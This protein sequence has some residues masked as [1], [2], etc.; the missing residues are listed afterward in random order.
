MKKVLA[1]VLVLVMV[2]GMSSMGFANNG[3]GKGL[4]TAPGQAPNFSK[5]ITTLVT[6]NEVVTEDENVDVQ[7]STNSP[8]ET[9]SET[10][11]TTETTEEQVKVYHENAHKPGSNQEGWYRY[12]TIITTV[13]T[14]TTRTWDEITTITTTTTT[15]TPI[16]TVETIETTI[17]HRGA[18]GSDGEVISETS[19][20]LSS[21]SIEGDPVVTIETN[22][23][24]TKGEV[25]TTT[26]S[27]TYSETIE[28][29]GWI[30]P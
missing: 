11:V 17:Q 18:P 28:G 20:T 15:V 12:D 4:A 19:R 16:T 30:K 25:A 1:V 27:Q 13:T 6:A 23:E 24:V 5:G 8:L 2:L 29:Q 10:N 21:V 26:S 22:T 7:T 9:K 14:T 3:K